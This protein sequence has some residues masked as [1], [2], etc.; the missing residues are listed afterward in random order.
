ELDVPVQLAVPAPVGVAPGTPVYFYRAGTLPDENGVEVP[1][2]I[3]VESGRVGTDGFA[4]TMSPPEP[5]VT[6]TGFYYIGVAES[7][8]SE[9][10]GRIVVSVPTGINDGGSSFAVGSTAGG[11]AAVGAFTGLTSGFVLTMPIGFRPIQIIEI[12]PAD[13][14]TITRTNVE[15]NR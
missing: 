4:R 13:L 8:G 9:G 15:V 3:Q 10:R 7:G 2:W 6:V 1:T 14:P 11:G 12:K 5:G